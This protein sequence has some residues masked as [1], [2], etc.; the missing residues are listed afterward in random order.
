VPR[1]VV[2]DFLLLGAPAPAGEVRGARGPRWVVQGGFEERLPTA[3]QPPAPDENEYGE[4]D[5]EEG[6]HRADDDESGDE[7]APAVGGR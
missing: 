4:A 2:Q 6:E 3:P 7:G 1:V 5:G